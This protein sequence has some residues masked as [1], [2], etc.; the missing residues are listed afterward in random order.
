MSISVITAESTQILEWTRTR[1]AQAEII[2]KVQG[3]FLT[4]IT[5]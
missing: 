5:P 2:I 1:T 4:K 3:P